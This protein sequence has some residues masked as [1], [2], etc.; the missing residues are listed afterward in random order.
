[1]SISFINPLSDSLYDQFVNSHPRAS[2]FHSSTWAR[3]LYGTYGFRPNSIAFIKNSQISGILP[4]METRGISGKGRC[5][6]LPFSDFCEP[7][8]DNQNDFQ[9]VF[10]ALK[11]HASDRRW[12]YIELRGDELLMPKEVPYETIY[13]HDLDLTR[14]ESEL[15]GALRESTRRNIRK[16]EKSGISITHETILEAT[17]EFYRLNC[18]TRREHGLPPQPWSFFKNIQEEILSKGM[19]FI[20]L[21]AFNK[22]FIAGN[23]FI[24]HG[25]KALYKYGASDKTY[26]NLRPSN[27]TMWEGI[28]KCRTIGCQTLNLG[29]TE[30]HHTGLQQFKRGFG[31]KETTINYYRY[32]LK[33]NH[34]LPRKKN[35]LESLPMS[36]MSRLP[37][38]VLRTI[39]DAF[40]KYAG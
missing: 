34:F 6:S 18:L 40:Y 30:T 13:T 14:D 16:A 24:Q 11:H 25:K 28:R 12:R 22:K 1:M 21:A 32:D 4:F 27:L 20:T 5:V 8:F 23:I 31:C 39:G 9:K 29:R 26:Q 38:Y 17:K 19:G 37:I 36:V 15:F 3:V 35:M 7:L 10:E 33:R 2:F